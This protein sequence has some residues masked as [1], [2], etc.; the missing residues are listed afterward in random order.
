M[1]FIMISKIAAF[2]TALVLASA[3]TASAQPTAHNNRAHA[4]ASSI[5]AYESGVPQQSDHLNCYLPSDT[6]DNEHMVTN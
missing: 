5:R 2:A 6:C 3:A 1:E 4:F